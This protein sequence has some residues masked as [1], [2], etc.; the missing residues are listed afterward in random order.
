M[1][2]TPLK[3]KFLVLLLS[4]N[5][6][7][8]TKDVNDEFT[9]YINLMIED[10]SER[11][12]KAGLLE[13]TISIDP[14]SHHASLTGLVD[15]VA[16]SG[17]KLY[18]IVDEY[19]SFANQL[20]MQVDT[21]GADPKTLVHQKTMTMARVESLLWNFGNVLKSGTTSGTIGRMFI[22]GVAPVAC[23]DGLSSLSMVED[24]SFDTAFEGLCGFY[25]S[26]V[27]RG[28]TALQL[29][30]VDKESEIFNT[31]QDNFNG[32]RFHADQ[33]EGIFNPQS[34]LYYLSNLLWGLSAIEDENVIN[35]NDSVVS[36]LRKHYKS[37]NPFSY[38]LSNFVF[39]SFVLKVSSAT[40][41]V[42][43]FTASKAEDA[44]ATMAYF[45]GFLTFDNPQ[46][47]HLQPILLGKDRLVC[48]NLV[49]KK[50]LLKVM[51]DKDEV[52][53]QILEAKK[54]KDKETFWR[55]FKDTVA[56][57]E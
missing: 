38:S 15:C 29:N 4:F 3:G 25:A 23:T 5:T 28:I 18:V 14:E 47:H 51:V 49:F 37:S 30:D 9:K 56:A 50:S 44:L 19:D 54:T 48:P 12:F 24:L 31:I 57:A 17:Q 21:S 42:D 53:T 20:L 6:L 52:V 16:R 26:D 46:H 43:L 27:R 22:T 35:V 40:R 33:V 41:S 8:T 55:E 11:Y 32:Y 34:C 36:F 7:D 10:F 13:E 39:E 2:P 45:H 1:N